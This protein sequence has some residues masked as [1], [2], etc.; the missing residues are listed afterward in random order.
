MIWHMLCSAL[1]LSSVTISER[2]G[3]RQTVN[4]WSLSKAR[5]KMTMTAGRKNLSG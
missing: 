5:V 1:C 3:E 2:E 4:V